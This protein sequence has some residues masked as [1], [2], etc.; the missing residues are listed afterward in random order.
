MEK[1][2]SKEK[3]VLYLLVYFIRFLT[4]KTRLSDEDMD[5]LLGDI[6]HEI[7]CNL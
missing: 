7:R 5:K 2:S 1:L 3:V 4:P 6:K